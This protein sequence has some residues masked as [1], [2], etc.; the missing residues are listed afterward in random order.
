[1]PP[2]IKAGLNQAL[3]LGGVGLI[4]GALGGWA[5]ILLGSE[6]DAVAGISAKVYLV[7]AFLLPLVLISQTQNNLSGKNRQLY[8]SLAGAETVLLIAGAG[9]AIAASALFLVM[10]TNIPFIIKG[11]NTVK[12]HDALYQHIGWGSFLTVL[13]V[14][15][16]VAAST[17]IWA[18][19]QAQ[20]NS[21]A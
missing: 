4:F 10:A 17:A 8:S 1:M 18:N 5:G 21:P 12:V 11:L 6:A 13:G 15:A 16:A 7:L 19:R 2:K 20:D 3:V 9:G 14:T